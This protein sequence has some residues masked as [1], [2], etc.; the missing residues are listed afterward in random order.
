V[1]VGLREGSSSKQKA[2][3]RAAGAVGRR[4]LGE[5]DVIMILLPDTEQAA[6]YEAEIAPHLVAGDAVFFAHGSISASGSSRPRP[7]WTW[8]WW[9]PRGPAT[10]CAGPTPRC[11]VLRWWRCR[12]TRRARPTT[13]PVLRPCHRATRAGVLDTTFA[14]ETETDL[15]GEQV[16]L[17][18]GLTALVQAGY[19][20]WSARA[21]SPSPPTSSASTS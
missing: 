7:T 18:G 17:C 16:V 19:E 1:R 3:R 21:T 8:P 13:W 6:V 14:E 15:F 2:R 9:H 4:R 10:W 12:P 5:A 20:T 11:G